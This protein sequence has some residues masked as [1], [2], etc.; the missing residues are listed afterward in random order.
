MELPLDQNLLSP[1]T[2]D[3]TFQLLA[4]LQ[5]QADQ[6]LARADDEGSVVI[7]NHHRNIEFDESQVLSVANAL[8]KRLTNIRGPPGKNICFPVLTSDTD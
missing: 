1:A 6:I 7:R 4:S 8:T 5:S 3:E 2:P